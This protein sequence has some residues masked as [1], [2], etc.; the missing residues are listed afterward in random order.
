MHY[1]LFWSSTG[2]GSETFDSYADAHDA[3]RRVVEDNRSSQSNTRP[4]PTS[5]ET[6]SVEPFT[7][8]CPVCAKYKGARR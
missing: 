3:A 5:N 4:L 7:E 8:D 6:F 2:L 1:H